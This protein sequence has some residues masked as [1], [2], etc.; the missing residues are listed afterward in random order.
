MDQIIWIKL[1]IRNT[2]KHSESLRNKPSKYSNHFAR[3]KTLNQKPYVAAAKIAAYTTRTKSQDTEDLGQVWLFS[4]FFL[5]HKFHSFI[6]L[7]IIKS[8]RQI[9]LLIY[10]VWNIP[11]GLVPCSA[12]SFN[13]SRV[14][15]CQWYNSTQTSPDCRC[16]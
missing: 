1:C 15:F 16:M 11:G 2:V 13:P 4:L 6:A 5:F 8:D 12:K 10:E 14:F 9:F 3:N 7:S